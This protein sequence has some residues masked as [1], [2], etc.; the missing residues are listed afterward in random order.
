MELGLFARGILVG[1]SIAAPIG[2]IEILCIPRT[3]AQGRAAG[4]VSG[5]LVQGSAG[6]AWSAVRF[7]CTW[8]G[9]RC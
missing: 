5:L 7:S 4:F 1:L 3:L 8:V 6:C 2:P 9:R